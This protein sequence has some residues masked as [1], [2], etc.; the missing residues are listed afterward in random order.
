MNRRRALVCG[1]REGFDEATVFR[2]LDQEWPGFVIFGDC[3]GPDAFASRWASVN[4]MDVARFKA[5]W[6]KH[7]KL[8][9]P[10]RNQ[11]MIDEGRPTEVIA[12]WDGESRGTLDMI[13]RAVKAGIPVKI[14][15][16]A[17]AGEPARTPRPEDQP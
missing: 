15:G 2:V 4:E 8:A 12:F 13:R 11:Q 1:S 16:R 17:G 9:G 5:D 10:I 14:Y 3:R 7:G 6:K